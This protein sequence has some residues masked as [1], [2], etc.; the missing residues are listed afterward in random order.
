MLTHKLYTV[1]YLLTRT[2]PKARNLL[3]YI[4]PD[5]PGIKGAVQGQ[6]PFPR[7]R[8]VC[9]L[10]ISMAHERGPELIAPTFWKVIMI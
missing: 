5:A 3:E 9:L 10:N 2:K 4:T 1:R 6:F 7:K 8:G